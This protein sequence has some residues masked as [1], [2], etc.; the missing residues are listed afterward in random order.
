MN[1]IFLHISLLTWFLFNYVALIFFFI[2]IVDLLYLNIVAVN[3][4]K[5]TTYSVKN[6]CAINTPTG[7][8]HSP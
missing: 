3:L 7:E 6:L 4:L 8:S 1:M 2:F 5:V